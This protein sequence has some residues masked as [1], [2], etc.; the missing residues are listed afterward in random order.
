VARKAAAKKAAAKK[1][2]DRTQLPP[3]LW[4]FGWAIASLCAV[5]QPAI[6]QETG[7]L[8]WDAPRGCPD[9]R[10]VGARVAR[11]LSRPLGAADVEQLH[12]AGRVEQ[13]A[14]GF[15]ANL[16]LTSTAGVH[17]RQLADPDCV[18]VADAAAFIVALAIDPNVRA[19]DAPL[20]PEERTQ[21][22]AGDGGTSGVST[23]G[24]GDATGD[25]S[26]EADVVTEVTRSDQ[27]TDDDATTRGDGEDAEREDEDEDE[28]PEA[29]LQI[30]AAAGLGMGIAWQPLP[31]VSPR[32]GGY[33]ALRVGDA[34]RIELAAGYAFERDE[35]V[36]NAN[37]QAGFH[38]IDGALVACL[39]GGR[40]RTELGICLGARAG[41]IRADT[42]E[43]SD[44]NS[45]EALPHAEVL[46]G[47]LLLHRLGAG[48]VLRI[49][50]WP[51]V[52][53]VRPRFELDDGVEVYQAEI[54]GFAASLGMEARFD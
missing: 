1:S 18:L 19:E 39:T 16:S 29:P 34:F 11:Y 17:Q 4:G 24:V 15:T 33:G 9:A 23:S 49:E 54:L 28:T 50:A 21:G 10:W 35:D 48:F 31:A 14:D 2:E 47:P 30:G 44:G 46:A 20:T 13:T 38:A 40:G 42:A 7:L 5:A 37:V 22:E 6:A 8:S 51:T 12:V 27:A 3:R 41:V 36:P 45:G 32:I 52:G 26:A 25:N 53:V 43:L